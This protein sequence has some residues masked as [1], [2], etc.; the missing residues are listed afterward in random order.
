MEQTHIREQNSTTMKQALLA[1]KDLRSRVAA[2]EYANTE[3]IAIIGMACRFPGG[4]NTPDLYWDVLKNG[5]DTISEIP[6]DRWDINAYYDPDPDTPGKMYGRWGGFLDQ[7]DQFDPNFFG[8]TPREAVSM[9]PQQRLLLEVCWEALENAGQAPGKLRGSQTGVF[10]GMSAAEY[11]Q[12][13]VDANGLDGVDPYVGTGGM[14]SITAGRLSYFLG[15]HGPSMTIDTACSSSLVTV[16]QACDSLRLK[17]SDLAL[18]GGVNLI[19]SPMANIFLARIKAAAFDGRCKTFDSAADGYVRGEGCGIVV[20]KRLS[21]ALASKD[22]ILALIRSSAVNHDGRSSGLTVPNGPAQQKVIQQA[23]SNLPGINASQIS[24]IEAHGTGTALGDPIEIRALASIY[25]KDRPKDKPLMIG[26]V[27]TNIGHLESAAGIASLIKLVLALQNEE[28]PP[29]LHLKNP[30]QM[31]DWATLPITIPTQRTPWA[32]KGEPRLAGVSAF[33]LSGTNAHIIVEEAPEKEVIDSKYDR[34]LHILALSAD[35]KV[36]LNKL[37]ANYTSYLKSQPHI[38]FENVVYTANTGRT[39]FSHRASII[40]ESTLHAAEQLDKLVAKEQ[41]SE[42]ANGDRNKLV[43][44]FTGQGS[45]YVN[46]GRELYDTQPLYRETMDN[47]NEI[48]QPY[49]QTSLLSVCFSDHDEDT[50]INDTSFTQP[51]LFAL[52][53]SLAK[54]WQSWGV[55]P[56]IL[57]GHSVGEYVAACIAGIFSLEDGLKL[58]A[59]RGELMSALPTGGRM[60]AVFA[61]E[62]QVKAVI[63]PYKDQVSIA[64]I[65]DPSNV[66][67]SGAEEAIEKVLAQL[68]NRNISARFLTVSHAFHSPLMEPI[69]DQFSE[70]ASSISYALPNIKIISNISGKLGRD[71]FCTSDYWRNHIRKAV[72]FADSITTI[73]EEN[74]NIFLEVGPKPTLLSI[75]KKCLPDSLEMLWLSSI[76]PGQS[77]WQQMLEGLAALYSRGVDIDWDRFDKGYLRHRVPLPTYPFQ[78]RR[79]WFGT[80]LSRTSYLPV[81]SF[82]HPLLGHRLQSASRDTQYE[83]QFSDS[84]PP[85]T[86]DHKVY[87]QLVVPVASYIEMGLAA[88]SKESTTNQYQIENVTIQDALILPIDKTIQIQTLVTPIN[89]D[90]SSFQVLS[91]NGEDWQLHASGTFQ[92]AI[93]VDRTETDKISLEALQQQCKQELDVQELY[94]NLNKTGLYYGPGFMGITRLWRGDTHAIGE[95]QLPPALSNDFEKYLLHPVLLDSCFQLLGAA[96]PEDEEAITNFKIYLPIGMERVTVY[97][98]VPMRLW[99]HTHILPN[100]TEKDSF[101]AEIHLFD[102]NGQIVAEVE[103]LYLKRVPREMLQKSVQTN[104]DNWLYEVV[105]ETYK[106][107]TSAEA[108]TES[109]GSWVIF[110]DE[111]GYGAKLTQHLRTQNENCIVVIP[112]N[113]K[114]PLDNVLQVNPSDA[115]GITSLLR[116]M[117]TQVKGVIYLWGLDSTPGLE[118]EQPQSCGAALHLTKAL[119]DLKINPAFGLLLVTKGAQPIIENSKIPLS[120]AQSPLW[121]LGAVIANEHPELRCTR[122]D[123]DPQSPPNEVELLISEVIKIRKE[124]MIALR[125]HQVYVARLNRSNLKVL[126]STSTTIHNDAT[127]LITGGSGDLGLEVAKWLVGQGAKN[128]VL[129][130]RQGVKNADRAT[131]AALEESNAKIIVFKAD[132]SNY[133]ELAEAFNQISDSLPPIKGVVH[134]AGVLDD[135]LLLQQ[136]W[137]RFNRVFLP[138]ISGA[139]NL[140]LLTQNTPLDFFVLFS[141][142]SSLLGTVGQANYSAANAF[143]DSL[144]HYRQTLGL[145]ALSINWAAWAGKGMASS[146]NSKQKEHWKQQ[147]FEF[148]QPAQGIDIF[149]RVLSYRKAQIGV[150]PVDLTKF[151]RQMSPNEGTSLF[152]NLLNSVGR[153]ITDQM[154]SANHEL[155]QQIIQASHDERLSLIQTYTQTVVAG[156]FK[157]ED[158]EII[159]TTKAL[160]EQGLDSL[161]AVEL[162]NQLQQDFGANIPISYFLEGTSIMALAKELLNTLDANDTFEVTSGNSILA[163]Q[164]LSNLDQLSDNEVDSLLDSLLPENEVE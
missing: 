83:I 145:P 140:H 114:S 14:F 47:C 91:L 65:N 86:K 56:D 67:I 31:I 118:K 70:I 2:L 41:I 149:A 144:A 53:Y 85:Y 59:A 81:G 9:D 88:A 76:K 138:K 23:L 52:E 143:L 77:D 97:D 107:S 64:A 94:A 16:H 134:A 34:P 26:S 160:N 62:A 21:D 40:A 103:N 101:S 157:I 51:A 109:G 162:K 80:T 156:V 120:I 27:K 89:M 75:A 78:R 119:I 93:S 146:L 152:A 63:A 128:L 73:K 113:T 48:L 37:I 161:M 4:S 8:I 133:D 25:G 50:R 159:D 135:G 71:E 106:P 96:L 61:N 29:H 122:I 46:M 22:N 155:I 132:V 110:A 33:G 72:R 32:S 126:T 36:A 82:I 15:L 148:I 38:P 105:W 87:D 116:N 123:I 154:L 129:I 79:Y 69:L 44:L 57:A 35:N 124:N 20:L 7:I 125:G 139:W 11:L 158:A 112:E 108:D 17:Q 18:A 153:E 164:I 74:G 84:W 6:P 151:L 115:L 60:A 49:L 137:E 95:L 66:V 111:N 136:D 90:K 42:S 5:V 142:M 99:G 45:Q 121:G 100:N 163:K 104:L 127:Y 130:S 147:G 39:H 54:L 13:Q 102:E 98:R 43:F 3:P 30:N 1:L 24:Y 131:V 68:S 10:V 117:T 92:K 58:I 28:I 12:L 55:E 150:W 141:S 19:L